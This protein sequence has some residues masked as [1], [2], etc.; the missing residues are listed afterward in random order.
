[1]PVRI[2]SWRT[3]PSRCVLAS[4][5]ASSAPRAPGSPPWSTSWCAST[6]SRAGASRSMAWMS[7][8]CHW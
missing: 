2:T 7:A 8:N 3:C 6:T 4:A 1:M 5:S